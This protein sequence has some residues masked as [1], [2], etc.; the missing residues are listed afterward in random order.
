MHGRCKHID[1]RYHFLRD[2][3]KDGV[4]ELK[5]CKSQN[6][7]ADIMTKALKLEAFCKLRE[8]LGVCDFSQ[9]D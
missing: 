9:E 4:I 3:S 5:F 7:L 8:A 6:Q 2:L 1:V